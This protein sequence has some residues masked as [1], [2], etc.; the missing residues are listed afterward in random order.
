[1]KSSQ[2]TY[3]PTYES[4]E[5]PAYRVEVLF[6]ADA[7]SLAAAQ[8]A[9]LTKIDLHWPSGRSSLLERVDYLTS[10]FPFELIDIRE[11]KPNSAE[12]GNW[13]ASFT[14]H[15][16]TADRP[17]FESNFASLLNRQPLDIAT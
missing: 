1:M 16:S 11:P 14:Y 12:L 6:R 9:D 13:I 5:D 7:Q 17:R 2:N 8:N 3:E 4:V 15:G 10:I